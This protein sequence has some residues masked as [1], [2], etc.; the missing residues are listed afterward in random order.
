MKPLAVRAHEKG[1]QLCC[2]VDPDTPSHFHGDPV[3]VRQIVTNLIGNA[4]KF[5]G[6]GEVTLKVDS[7][8]RFNDHVD[9]QF[10]ITDTG[11]GIPADKVDNIFEAF[12]QADASTTRLFGGT[13]LGLAISTRLVEAMGGKLQVESSLGTGTT[14]QFAVALPVADSGATAEDPGPLRECRVLVADANE[15]NRRII[16]RML[17]SWSMEVNEADGVDEAIS[18]SDSLPP[19]QFIVADA[20]LS[21]A[22]RISAARDDS[23]PAIIELITAGGPIDAGDPAF[24]GAGFGVKKLTITIEPAGSLGSTETIEIPPD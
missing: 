4:I 13:G 22:Q 21:L 20:E 18:Q 1:I 19:F 7:L 5:T 23:G 15:T 9:L 2:D 17:R 12:A 14:F 8:G 24:P 6:E 3:R 10:Q 16:A 11:I